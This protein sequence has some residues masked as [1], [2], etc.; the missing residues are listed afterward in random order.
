MTHPTLSYK[1]LIHVRRKVR[2]AMEAADTAK[3]VLVT[4][5]SGIHYYVER[6]T[7]EFSHIDPASLSA[8]VEWYSAKVCPNTVAVDAY[9]ASWVA[10][11]LHPDSI[12]RTPSA[13]NSNTLNSITGAA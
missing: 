7:R 12:D 5:V 11:D 13:L 1:S 8:T 2:K 3:R 10:R 4:P 9:D 6:P